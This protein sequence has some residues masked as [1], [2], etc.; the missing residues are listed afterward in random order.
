MAKRIIES[1]T[2]RVISCATCDLQSLCQRRFNRQGNFQ[3]T[4]AVELTRIY[5][6][7]TYHARSGDNL[8][9]NSGIF[10]REQRREP[11]KSRIGS[12]KQG[13]HRKTN[14]QLIEGR[15]TLSDNREIN[16][17]GELKYQPTAQW[18]GV[19]TMTKRK[20]TVGGHSWFDSNDNRKG[21]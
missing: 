19:W 3:V 17:E 18:K 16:Q 1:C 11:P 6:G 9:D 13:Y 5:Y 12:P 4:D 10:T 15:F 8:T 21:Y 14:Q 2:R 20:R 7:S